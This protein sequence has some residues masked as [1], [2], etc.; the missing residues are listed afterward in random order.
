MS[1]VMMAG[2]GTLALFQGVLMYRMQKKIQTQNEIILETQQSEEDS[3]E[4]SK[5]EGVKEARQRKA[6]N[7][8]IEIDNLAASPRNSRIKNLA[9]QP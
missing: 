4:E 7:P 3:A 6:N 2:F 1:M 8:V 9:P 5:D